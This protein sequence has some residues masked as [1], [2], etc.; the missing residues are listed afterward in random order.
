MPCECRVRSSTAPV[1]PLGPGIDGPSEPP[2]FPGRADGVH[3]VARSRASSALY[4]TGDP[5]D[6]LL[7][8][9]RHQPTIDPGPRMAPSRRDSRD[10]EFSTIATPRELDARPAA[11]VSAM[12]WLLP[13]RHRGFRPSA[14]KYSRP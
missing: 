2:R 12:A 13:P 14:T 9:M 8:Q 6:V 10:A 4:W 5:W 7:E 3:T 1:N 11:R